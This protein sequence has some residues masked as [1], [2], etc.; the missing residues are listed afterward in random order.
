MKESGR[1]VKA[2]KGRG[3]DTVEIMNVRSVTLGS[4]PKDF[5]SRKIT[6]MIYYEIIE[7]DKEGGD[8]H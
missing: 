2:R 4:H 7:R 1:R 8:A 5:P 6:R 3:G